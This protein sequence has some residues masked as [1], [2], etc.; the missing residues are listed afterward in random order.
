M[1]YL[2]IAIFILLL[3]CKQ[4]TAVV[5]A[6]T[7]TDTATQEWTIY[8][9]ENI[10][11]DFCQDSVL[12]QDST[13]RL[14]VSLVYAYPSSGP[15]KA[16][17]RKLI[18]DAVEPQL[19]RFAKHVDMPDVNDEPD[20]PYEELNHNFFDVHPSNCFQDKNIISC[21]FGVSFMAAYGI[22]AINSLQS[23]TFD[24]QSGKRLYAREYF[25]LGKHE[26]ANTLISLLDKDY[27]ALRLQMTDTTPAKFYHLD[28][29][30]FVVQPDAIIFSFSDYALGQG[31]SMLASRIDKRQLSKIIN[32]RYK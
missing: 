23:F 16:A 25:D 4:K 1:K 2:P 11:S 7:P 5:T 27:K 18:T 14:E 12:Y 29:I 13:R 32:S 22:H 19:Q 26:N 30:D 20:L 9:D 21:R 24:K 6:H 31:P 17:F 28:S 3:S 10:P 8:E 15:Y